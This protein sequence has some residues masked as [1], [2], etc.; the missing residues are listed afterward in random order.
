MKYDFDYLVVGVGYAGHIASSNLIKRRLV[1]SV[2][3]V[4]WGND[5]NPWSN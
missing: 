5:N 1:S 2:Y 4:G 3:C